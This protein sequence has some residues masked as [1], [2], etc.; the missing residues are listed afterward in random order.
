[1]HVWIHQ[2]PVPLS[3]YHGGR[4]AGT[5]CAVRGSATQ[6]GLKSVSEK[7]KNYKWRTKGPEPFSSSVG[8][9]SDSR[10]TPVGAT[11]ESR[12]SNQSG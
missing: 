11:S 2:S 3:P 6:T 8:G 9:N 4:V 10:H 1:M 7:R 5:A 12:L